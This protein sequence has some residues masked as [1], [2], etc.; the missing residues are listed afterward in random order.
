MSRDSIRWFVWSLALAPEVA[1]AHLPGVPAVPVLKPGELVEALDV[2]LVY[3]VLHSGWRGRIARL[4]DAPGRT[5]WGR[6]KEVA[7]E[8]VDSMRQLEASLSQ[9][10]E[11][12]RVRVRTATGVLHTATALSAPAAYLTTDGPVSEQFM[13]TLAIAAEK[14]ALPPDYVDRLRA[15]A[16]IV[17]TVQRASSS[18]HA[19][20]PSPRR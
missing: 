6:L 9:S 12:R 11:A 15:E 5:V 13:T 10:T 3:D 18:P 20:S 19:T 8:A 16:Q 17:A 1:R 2:D 14:A 4:V 7:P